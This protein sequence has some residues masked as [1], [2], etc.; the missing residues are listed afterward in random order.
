MKKQL[1]TGLLALF[2]SMAAAAQ[3]GSASSSN[4]KTAIGVK[5]WDGGGIN[6]KT[7][8]TDNTALEFIGFFYRGGTRITGLYELHGDLNTE[9]NLKWYVGFGAHVNLLKNATGGGLDGVIGMDYKFPNLPL[10]IAADWQPGV[11]LGVGN[12]NGFDA[13][14]GGVAFRFTL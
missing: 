7:F 8:L 1:F 5:L 11:Q 2:I 12:R 3:N 4:Y 9:G 13:S 6:L 10:N 14:R